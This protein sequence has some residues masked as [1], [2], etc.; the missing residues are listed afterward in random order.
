MLHGGIGVLP[1]QEVFESGG[2]VRPLYVFRGDA[3]GEPGDS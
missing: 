3:F 2:L 1:F